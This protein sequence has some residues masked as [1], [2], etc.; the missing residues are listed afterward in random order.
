LGAGEIDLV[1]G[2]DQP[3]AWVNTSWSLADDET[4]QQERTAL[5]RPG[6]P[7]KRVLVTCETANRRAPPGAQI[8]EAWRYLA[9]PRV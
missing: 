7:A 8:V 3:E 6:G 2:L 4:W 9:D 1:V 5:Q